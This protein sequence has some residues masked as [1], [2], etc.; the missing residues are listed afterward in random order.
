MHHAYIV[1][2]LCIYH[3]YALKVL[4][5]GAS[6]AG[7]THLLNQIVSHT[8]E[9]ALLTMRYTLEKKLPTLHPLATL[10]PLAALPPPYYPPS[11]PVGE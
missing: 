7:K 5:L 10:Q 1:L 9:A 6:R 2:M 8:L 4:V 3:A 11:P